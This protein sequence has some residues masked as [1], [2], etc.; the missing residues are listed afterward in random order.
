MG[1]LLGG[2]EMKTSTTSSEDKRN[3]IDP[4]EKKEWNAPQVKEFGVDNTETGTTT[5]GPESSPWLYYTS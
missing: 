2:A 1:I 5:G 4:D 3:Q